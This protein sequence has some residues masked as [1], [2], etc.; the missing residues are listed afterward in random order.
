MRLP[1]LPPYVVVHAALMVFLL[2]GCN[3]PEPVPGQAEVKA[4]SDSENLLQSLSPQMKQLAKSFSG[5]TDSL[6]FVSSDVA[7]IGID[8]FTIPGFE[9]RG[10]SPAHTFEWPVKSSD[11][12]GGLAGL[13]QPLS[14]TGKLRDVQLGS[15]SASFPSSGT[16]EIKSKLEGKFSDADG[17]VYGLKGYQTLTWVESNGWKL[18]RWQQEKL[19]LTL[20][21]RSLFEDTTALTVP[22]EK[23]RT[24]LQSSSHQEMI[25]DYAAQASRTGRP[26]EAPRL[27]FVLFGDWFSSYQ[28]PSV[29]VLDL[30]SDGHDDLFVTDRWQSAQLLQ[31]NGDGTFE[32]VTKSSGLIVKE[33]ANCT[34]F[35]DFDNDG[36]SDAFVGISMGS[37]R[38]YT[39]NDGKFELDE[40]NSSVIKNSRFVVAASVVDINNDGL[41]D[42]Y[43]ST[44]AFGHGNAEKW[45]KRATRGKLDQKKMLERIKQQHSYVDRAGPPNI[46]LMNRG[47][48]FEWAKIDDTLKQ[49]RDSYQ[50]SWTDIDNDGDLDVYICNDFANDVF[51]R[52]DT[53]QGSFEPT[54]VDA[55][56]EFIGSP[57]LNFAM[58]TSWGD[59]DNDGDLDLYVSNMYSKAGIRICKQLDTVDPRIT[60]SARGNFLYRNDDGKLTQVAGTENDDQ[61]VAIVGW[62]F[63]GQF[64][65]FDNDGNLDL[66]VPSGFYSPPAKLH[67]DKDL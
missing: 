4:I 59:F 45:Y 50:N 13:F 61:H 8:D 7:C 38:F 32:D 15:V 27:P 12:K 41:L 48:K 23:T 56:A 26:M 22:D 6:S 17:Q 47:G 40:T 42:L 5:D 20:A 54:F 31:N 2:A 46:V 53:P 67:T 18:K 51:L 30:N 55:T 65:D 28:Y 1:P 11:D 36:D 35:A 66:Y 60:V 29:S 37:S 58:G 25:L 9:K 63:G 64:A 10:T 14:S 19:K 43:L 62:S 39:N 16:F 24:K 57:D 49:F 21:S 34:Y 52:N 33:L 3:T 44:Y